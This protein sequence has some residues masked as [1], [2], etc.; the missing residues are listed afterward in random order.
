MVNK[1]QATLQIKQK[2]N[3]ELKNGT[4]SIKIKEVIEKP[5]IG[6]VGDFMKS[7][8]SDPYQEPRSE[9]PEARSSNQDPPAEPAANEKIVFEEPKEPNEEAPVGTSS[10]EA[11]RGSPPVIKKQQTAT[12]INELEPYGKEHAL[13]VL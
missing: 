4:Y 2:T 7:A 13:D 5:N 8:A 3:I 6:A 11:Q 1:K 12:I 10:E 9:H